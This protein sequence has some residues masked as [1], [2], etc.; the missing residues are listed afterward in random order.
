VI[1]CVVKNRTFPTVS[2]D[3]SDAGCTGNE[4]DPC[5]ELSMFMLVGAEG[6]EVS[7]PSDHFALSSLG[8]K[9]NL[10]EFRGLQISQACPCFSILLPVDGISQEVGIT[11][12]TR[13]PVNPD[14]DMHFHVQVRSQ[15]QLQTWAAIADSLH[16][17]GERPHRTVRG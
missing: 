14:D 3:A 4:S 6:F 8:F 7:F 12:I 2:C 5:L 13:R 17:V 10:L 16:S 9:G 15:Y 11:G 1:E